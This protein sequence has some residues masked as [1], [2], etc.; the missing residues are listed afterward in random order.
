M[1]NWYYYFSSSYLFDKVPTG[2][3]NLFI[4]LLVF[5]IILIIVSIIS[6]IV[7]SRKSRKTPPYKAIKNHIY[8]CGLTIGTI[9]LILLFFR[10]QSIPYL[11]SRILILI[12]LLAFLVWLVYII[13]YIKIHLKHNLKAYQ[14]ELK[15]QSYLPQKK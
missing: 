13:I 7:L 14:T 2:E 9:G 8:N 12:L 11:S 5:F 1:Q 15:Y 3:E 10:W 4:G 6:Y